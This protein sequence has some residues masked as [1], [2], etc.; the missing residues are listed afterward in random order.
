MS[1]LVRDLKSNSSGWVHETF[2]ERAKFAWQSGYGA[3][4]V[5]KSI[6]EKV[7]GYIAI[8]KENHKQETFKEEYLRFLKDHDL[9]YDERYLWD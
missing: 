3:F 9:E 8:Q 1:D 7:K 6:I 4:S 2:P 5:S